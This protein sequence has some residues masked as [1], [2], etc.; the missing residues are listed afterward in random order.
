MLQVRQFEAIS[1]RSLF[2]QLTKRPHLLRIRS[3]LLSQ[4]LSKM[5]KKK[6]QSQVSNDISQLFHKVTP[7]PMT[8]LK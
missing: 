5:I 4:N 8:H 2:I 7:D 1:K 3:S 6:L